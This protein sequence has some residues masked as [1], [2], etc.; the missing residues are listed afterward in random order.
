MPQVPNA[1]TVCLWAPAPDPFS[2]IWQE[3]GTQKGDLCPSAAEG[4]SGCPV[5]VSEQRM[6]R[7]TS[8]LQALQLL[9]GSGGQRLSL[10]LG[11]AQDMLSY[12]GL[13]VLSQTHPSAGFFTLC[14]YF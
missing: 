1:V 5:P 13:S 7:A 14:P 6:L 11:P 12:S 2:E 10:I 8:S 9:S 4:L 3:A